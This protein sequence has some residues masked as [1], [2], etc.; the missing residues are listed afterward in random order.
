MRSIVL[1]VLLITAFTAHAQRNSRDRDRDR[2]KN[3]HEDLSVL[4]PKFEHTDTAYTQQQSFVHEQVSPQHTVNE[5]VDMILDSIDAINSVRKYIPGF[6][7]QIYSGTNRDDANN[8]KRKMLEEV[9]MRADLLYEQPKWRVKTG[10]YF[11]TIEAQK[12][13]VKIR[14][15]FPN[16]ILVPEIIAIR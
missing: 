11:T 12:D 3:Y 5:K 2:D 10:K 4:R 15:S 8:T 9:E 14:R 7:I 13:L 6:T 16:A 1:L